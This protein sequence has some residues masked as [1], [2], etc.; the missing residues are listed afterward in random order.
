M[1]DEGTLRL[2]LL[3]YFG[4]VPV[5]RIDRS[6]VQR[7]VNQHA[8]THAPR[9]VK[10]DYGVLRAVMAFALERDLIGRTPCRGTRLPAVDP[11]DGHLISAAE[12]AVL[13][14]ALDDT[15]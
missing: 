9:T 6:S 13:A 5:G 12:L 4:P 15:G 11:V 10:R 1:R 7:W 2:H 8:T 3:P 14:E